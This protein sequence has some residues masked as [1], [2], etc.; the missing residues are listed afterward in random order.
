MAA[1]EKEREDPVV[2]EPSPSQRTW[3]IVDL[4]NGRPYFPQL[5]T[6]KLA[7][8]E[9]AGLLWP[10]PKDHEWRRR[11]VVQLWTKPIRGGKDWK[12]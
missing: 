12:F 3:A 8:Q 6:K 9:L 4:K 5:W 2:G 11:L 1:Q 10:Y 7:E